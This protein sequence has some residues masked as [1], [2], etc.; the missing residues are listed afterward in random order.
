M[1]ERPLLIL[2]NLGPPLERIKSGGGGP[3][4]LRS[5]SRE[6]QGS[7]FSSIFV[8]M[9]ESFV[10]DLPDGTSPENIL[11]LETMSKIEEFKTAVSV[12][13]G[14]NWLAEVDIDFIESDELFFDRP[15]IG[16]MYFRKRVPAISVEESKSLKDIFE[17]Q[18]LLDRHGYL[19]GEVSEE[20]IVSVIPNK[21][22]GYSE[23][24][25]AAVQQ[26]K[27]K[28]LTGRMY[29][30]L[31]NR[32]ALA[33]VKTLFDSWER[34][35]SLPKGSASWAQ[36]FSHLRTIR[37]WNVEDRV[38]DTGIM[39]FWEEELE[40]K[41]GTSSLISFEVELC[42]SVDNESRQSRQREIE[43][44]VINEGGSV[45]TTCH[46]SEIK[47]HALK[48]EL[49]VDS[50]EKVLSGNYGALFRYGGVVFFRPAPQC[51][52]EIAPDGILDDVQRPEPP[53]GPPVIALLDGVPL[54]HHELLEGTNRG[55]RSFSLM[56]S[57][58]QR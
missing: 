42:Y 4:H 11:V 49:P 32:Q 12:V 45:I 37:Y 54:A 51:S 48:I 46:I 2:P 34:G 30:S 14:L 15:K 33:R 38:R 16:P 6:E 7:R 44:L 43:Q 19:L 31:S 21:L 24:I 5:P 41:R 10:T 47:F 23:L 56:F 58:S 53:E 57:L 39:E 1:P 27:G 3:G 9:L 55:V 17:E 36:I 13:P 8:S 25:L 22:E 20:Q 52:F 40:V 18:Q 26:E 50:V 35:E 29:L 28:P